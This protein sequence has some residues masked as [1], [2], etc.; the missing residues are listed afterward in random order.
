MRITVVAL[1]WSLLALPCTAQERWQLT[2]ASGQYHW[3]LRLVRLDGEALVVRHADTT[4]AVPVREI[5]ELRRVAKSLKRVGGGDD[6]RAVLGSLMGAD[7]EVY[8]LTLATLPDRLAIIRNVL[9]QRP[10]P[11]P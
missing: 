10:P 5:T 1:F 11:S 4:I 8:Q 6:G 3:D 2:L 7:D 9:Q